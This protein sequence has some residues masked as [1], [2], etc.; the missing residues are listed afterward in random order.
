MDRIKEFVE[1]KGVRNTLYIAGLVILMILIFLHVNVG[2][3]VSDT[4]YSLANFVKF[5]SDSGT[6]VLATFLANFTGAVL[7]RLP[8]G[9]TML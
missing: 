6:W 7:T 4:G 2:V 3:E 9:S 5:F 8:F 1:K